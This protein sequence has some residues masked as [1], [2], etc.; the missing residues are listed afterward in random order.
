MA[1]GDRPPEKEEAKVMARID[2]MSEVV[3]KDD[4]PRPI[5]RLPFD[6]EGSG[7]DYETARQA[8]L[9]PDATGHWPSRDPR[10]GLLLKGRKHETWDLLEE[11]EREAGYVVQQDKDGRYYSRPAPQRQEPQWLKYNIE[12]RV[13]RYNAKD[14]TPDQAKHDMD[15]IVR[16]KIPLPPERA[17]GRSLH[18][19]SDA[20]IGLRRGTPV[21]EAAWTEYAELFG[22]K[23]EDVTPQL[24]KAAIE[25]RTQ[26]ADEA[27][28]EGGYD[29]VGLRQFRE[30]TAAMTRDVN[31]KWGSETIMEY[32]I[33]RLREARGTRLG[34]MKQLGRMMA[35]RT[36]EQI[37]EDEA[38]LDAR[39]GYR[40]RE[41]QPWRAMWAEEM[42]REFHRKHPGEPYQGGYEGG[43]PR[44]KVYLFDK[45]N[46]IYEAWLKE[47]PDALRAFFIVRQKKRRAL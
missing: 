27:E 7:Y 37:A 31:R 4:R 32:G 5:L 1:Q 46:E 2:E 22:V 28:E 18:R 26:F 19:D 23:P 8:G 42:L 29:P 10:T 34:K 9:S 39:P 45:A 36:P 11:G 20:A 12:G 35:A 43:V 16:D 38:I 41:N 25:Q 14:F 6:P 47:H 17:G 44:D 3:E 24:L 33:R 40:A 21:G 15:Y 30:D 13:Y